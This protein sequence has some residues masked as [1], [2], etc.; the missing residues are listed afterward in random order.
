[1]FRRLK[2]LKR[3]QEVNLKSLEE[4]LALLERVKTHRSS[5][6]DRERLA[7]LIRVTLEV[8]EHIQ[9]EPEVQTPLVS[10]QPRTPASPPTP[11]QQGPKA[12]RRRQRT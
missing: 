8:T 11:K 2:M 4:A 3:L 5:A 10:A 9:A 6:E 1:M 12:A 7:H